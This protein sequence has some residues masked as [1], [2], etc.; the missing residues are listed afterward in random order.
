MAAGGVHVLDV[1]L[2][3]GETL[4]GAL[5]GDGGGGCNVGAGILNS[6]TGLGKDAVETVCLGDNTLN[7]VE[8][9]SQLDLGVLG[10]IQWVSDK[11]CL[12]VCVGL[13]TG[14]GFLDCGVCSLGRGS[15]RG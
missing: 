9:V 10:S 14:C 11:D 1:V 3:N 15:Y 8:L 2:A 4:A 13:F 6:D 7:G 5:G 12:G